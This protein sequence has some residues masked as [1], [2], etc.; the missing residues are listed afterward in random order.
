MFDR[1]RIGNQL[2]TAIKLVNAAK[3]DTK[4][5]LFNWSKPQRD[6]YAVY[7]LT[8][9]DDKQ[10]QGLIALKDDHKNSAVYIHLAEVAPHN[11]GSNGKY[12]GTGQHLFAYA[13]KRSLDLEYGMVYFDAKSKLIKHYE[14]TVGACLI[15]GQRMI[16]EGQALIE[17]VK[18][19]YDGGDGV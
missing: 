12:S 17:L 11:Y 9:K 2:E 15:G 16:I 14:K 5:W 8:L 10:I 6:G 7:A 18:A 19:Y 1:A 4:A 3:I 13:G